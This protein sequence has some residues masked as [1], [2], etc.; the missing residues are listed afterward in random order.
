MLVTVIKRKQSILGG[1][2]VVD[3]KLKTRAQISQESYIF[4]WIRV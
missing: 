4:F 3:A 1:L 2:P